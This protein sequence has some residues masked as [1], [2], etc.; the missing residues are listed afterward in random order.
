VST[1]QVGTPRPHGRRWK[2]AFAANPNALGHTVVQR[3]HGGH[4]ATDLARDEQEL[5]VGVH[6]A[7][8]SQVNNLYL[9]NSNLAHTLPASFTAIDALHDQCLQ[10]N[11][12][13]GTL[14]GKR[15]RRVG[16]RW[17]RCPKSPI[18]I[19]LVC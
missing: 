1:S 4:G 18:L 16:P 9:K 12:L 8:P 10:T 2:L 19:T 6:R 3:R 7:I 11:V 17:K 15:L 14:N 5:L 13:S